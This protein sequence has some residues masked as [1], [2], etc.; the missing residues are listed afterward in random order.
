MCE[1][2]FVSMLCVYDSCFQINQSNYALICFG[3]DQVSENNNNLG[4][5]RQKY[6]FDSALT[7]CFTEINQL[8]KQILSVKVSFV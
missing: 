3:Y 5:R 7:S 6:D 4:I 1:C 2:I 8:I